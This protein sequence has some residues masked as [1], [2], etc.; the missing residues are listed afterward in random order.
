MK[1]AELKTESTIES[2]PIAK[3]IPHP[4]NPNQM[5]DST[6]R[7][8]VRN[9]ERTGLYEPIIV[10]P[11][12]KEKGSFQIINGHHRVK[13][14]V[15]LG[16]KEADCVVWEV[17]DEQTVVLLATL[18]RLTGSD[19]P[20]KKIE[21]LKQLKERFDSVDLA[22]I[23]PQTAKQIERLTN[24]KLDLVPVKFDAETFAVPLVFFVTAEQNKIIEQALSEVNTLSGQTKAQCRA[25]AITEIAKH[26][27]TVSLPQRHQGTK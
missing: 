4:A 20:A 2:I 6:F 17:D 11:H 15:K 25:A 23:L 10:R 12:P 27:L 26:F 22:K 21:L 8:L 14:L 3:L 9:I 18:N 19:V 16:K 1:N 7:K 13:A 24:L 5:S